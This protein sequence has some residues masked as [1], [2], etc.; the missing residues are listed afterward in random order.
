MAS[1]FG[2]LAWRP[3]LLL[4]LAASSAQHRVQAYL[5]VSGTDILFRGSAPQKTHPCP[6]CRRDADEIKQPALTRFRGPGRLTKSGDV[7][8]LLLGMQ[9]TETI[10]SAA[11]LLLF[12]GG[13]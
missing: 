8:N 7:S 12:A 11:K 13:G 1:S 6:H 4:L 3:P 5:G 9:T 10:W 2:P